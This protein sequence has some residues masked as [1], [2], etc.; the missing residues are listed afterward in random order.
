MCNPSVKLHSIETFFRDIAIISGSD[1]QLQSR[2]LI[3]LVQLQPCETHIPHK[4]S[5]D[6]TS[7]IKSRSQKHEQNMCGQICLT[8][9]PKIA[10]PDDPGCRVLPVEDWSKLVKTT[11][12]FNG[13]GSF[14][15]TA[16]G[17][18]ATFRGKNL[19]QLK[20]L[21]QSAI[22]AKTAFHQS[23]KM[24]SMWGMNKILMSCKQ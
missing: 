16:F 2:N 15:G 4:I 12:S 14:C 8:D 11:P 22:A 10:S 1:S 21:K 17:G 6:L 24:L 3:C 20:Q 5:Q 13:S 18:S 7:H 19:K 23:G 9:I